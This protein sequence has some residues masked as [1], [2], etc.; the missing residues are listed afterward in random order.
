MGGEMYAVCSQTDY[1]AESAKKNWGVN[2]EVVADPKVKIA[3]YLLSKN[4]LEVFV[5]RDPPPPALS[6][7]EV[8]GGPYEVGVYQPA[9]IVLTR[10]LQPLFTYASVPG[11]ANAGGASSRPDAATVL[12]AVKEVLQGGKP[13]EWKPKKIP[14]FAPIFLVMYFF[15][16]GNFVRPVPPALAE[17]GTE[18]R[19]VKALALVKLLLALVSV[20]VLAIFFPWPTLAG[21]A[22]YFLYVWCVWGSWIRKFFVVDARNA[23]ERPLVQEASP[24]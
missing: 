9:I 15:A 17:D 16:G 7:K 22:V 2:Y 20:V 13:A 23:L 14:P 12:T 21:V 24:A 6:G 18:P 3:E 19:G 10:D 4:L 5:N 11:L 1:A 8:P